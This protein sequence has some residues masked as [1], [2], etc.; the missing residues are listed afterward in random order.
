M[1]GT[2]PLGSDRP[3]LGIDVQSVQSLARRPIEATAFWLAVA[4]PLAY[5]WLLYGGAS[6][7]ELALL[8]ALVACNA[9]ALVLGREHN[10]P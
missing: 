7:R 5:P 1:S 4:L 9:L 6:G 3:A 10:R 2:N 8:V